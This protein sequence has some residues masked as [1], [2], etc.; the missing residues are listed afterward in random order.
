MGKLVGLCGFAQVGKD[1]AA[2]QLVGFTR[3]AFADKL[4]AD[5]KPVLAT[6]GLDLSKP[7]DKA[8]ARPLLV[9]WG[10]L[11][12]AVN[13]DHWTDYLFAN[14]PDGDV[15]ITDV[16]YANEVE[17]IRMYGG[18]VIHIHR[19]GYLAANLEEEDSIYKILTTCALSGSICND[20]TIEELGKKVRTL[21]DGPWEILQFQTP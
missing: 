19:P 9:E 10:R 14:L 4:K 8:V 15:V 20:G 1:T 13:P 16:R 7:L 12:R 18:T 21:I 2:S 3:A 5:L 11:A 6:V 17:R